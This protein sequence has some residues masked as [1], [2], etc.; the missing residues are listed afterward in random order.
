MIRPRLRTRW[1]ACPCVCLA[2][3]W[4]VSAGA[5]DPA[6]KGTLSGKVVDP[7]GRPIGHARVW[8]EFLDTKTSSRKPLA[9]AR[10]DNEGRFRLGPIEAVYR[11][12]PYGLRIEA[13][14][15]ASECI[16]STS[17]SVFPG[18]DCD[19]GTIQLDPG[20]VFTGTVI[21][22]DGKP[23]V[24][25]SV[26]AQS[27]W[28]VLG[29][30]IGGI[31]SDTSLRTDAAG[32]F[33]TKPLPV[34]HLILS[35]RVPDRQLAYASEQ[36]V[37]PGGEEDVGT[38][39]LEKDVPVVGVVLSEDGTP[40]P[41]VH[42][43]GT[44]G[45]TA[46]TDEQ[47]RFTLRGFGPNPSFQMNVDKEGYAPLLGRVIVA[48]PGLTYKVVRGGDYQSKKPAKTLTVILRRAGC[49]E[50]EAI[51]ADTAEPVRLDKIVVCNFVR[52]SN[53]EIVLRGCQSDFQQSQPGRFRA[54]FPAPDEYH[55]TFM[56]AGYH[57]AEVYTPKVTE[58]KT[59]SGIVVKMKKT[60]DGSTS[61][62]G[63][64]SLSGTVTRDGRAVRSGWVGLWALRRSENA[65][66]SFVQRGRTVAGGP[67]PY[68]GAVIHDGS[69][70]LEVP[71]QSETWYVVVEEPGHALTQ[72][73]PVSVALKEQKKLDIT[74]TPGGHIRGRVT[75]IPAAW[76]GHVWVVA[77][78]KTA[79]RAEV[80]VDPRGQFTLPALPAGEY[81]LKAGHNGYADAEVYPG[82]LAH[83]NR[84]SYRE[85]ADPWK[86][87]KVVTVKPG[88]D[89]AIVEVEFPR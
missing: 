47:G 33:R 73:G 57:H 41:S 56:A 32:R 34:G 81:G 27:C 49:I 18:L 36:P 79:V 9:E 63:V 30:T 22:F 35:V 61:A 23:V 80:R 76:D 14:G 58:L 21:D 83:E 19:L 15:F 87:A 40:I 17:L 10:T 53:G 29:H 71:F 20:R 64:Q 84:E 85:I 50:G 70:R 28:H 2:A 62:I 37:A 88:R 77:F 54:S 46:T 59:V 31:V 51:D 89:T 6:P 86:R 75:G 39:R 69:Y 82:K 8:T 67:I 3:L 52:K 43:G 5:A 4:C 11:R 78:S 66:N 72:V 38:I 45:H 1:A 25:A 26:T 68:A 12:M 44:V 55:V 60:T 7:T 13:D 24:G 16:S 74:C 65:V 48:A 42:I